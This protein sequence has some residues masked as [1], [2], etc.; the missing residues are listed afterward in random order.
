MNDASKKR[1]SLTTEGGRVT[2]NA[3]DYL[4][5]R[6]AAYNGICQSWG[7]LWNKER[8]PNSRNIGPVANVVGL[9]LDFH[10]QGFVIES[11]EATRAAVRNCIEAGLTESE[12]RSLDHLNDVVDS[13]APSGLIPYEYQRDGIVWLHSRR[14]A[15]LGD[16]MGLGKTWQ[17]LLALPRG[18]AALI[19]SPSSIKG[20]TALDAV[21]LRPDLKVTMFAASFTQ[22]EAAYFADRGIAITS[23]KRLCREGEIYITNYESTPQVALVTQSHKG[24]T[25]NQ[26]FASAQ[27]MAEYLADL[28][29]RFGD[30]IRDG[31]QVVMEQECFDAPPRGAVLIG[32][33]IHR[34][35]N[36]KALQTMRWN[37]L[38]DLFISVDGSVWGV[39]GTPMF[40]RPFDLMGVLSGLNLFNEAFG[41]FNN[42]VDLMGGSRGRYGYEWS[43]YIDPKAA[44]CMKRVM[45]RREGKDVLDMLP[46]IRY[47]DIE[48][49]CGAELQKALDDIAADIAKNGN[50]LKIVEKELEEVKAIMKP[51]MAA[52][53]QFDDENF[54]KQAM[55][56]IV[57]IQGR[58][59]GIVREALNSVVNSMDFETLTLVR[60]M[61]AKATGEA[62]MDLIEDYEEQGEA[63]VVF[64]CFR[65][66]I[67]A[68]GKRKGWVT[69]T[70]SK[71][72]IERAEAVERH[73][74]GQTAGIALTV[75]AGREGLTLT[76]SNNLIQIDLSWNPSDNS[77]A[78]FRVN[79]IGQ[80]RPVLVTRLVVNHPLVQRIH[81][82]LS[83]KERMHE[84][85]I[86]AASTRTGLAD[87][88]S[89]EAQEALAA[90]DAST[91]AAKALRAAREAEEAAKAAQRE[92]WAQ[93]KAERAARAEKRK[94][95][96]AR[97]HRLRFGENPDGTAA[98]ERH[99]PRN[100]TEAWVVRSVLALTADDPDRASIDNGV[101]FNKS[102]S[103]YGHEMA[104]IIRRGLGLTDEQYQHAA[105]MLAKYHGQIGRDP[106]KEEV[107]RE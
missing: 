99:E 16:E 100:E 28:A 54:K 41:S 59:D 76:R 37:A 84:G 13:I 85:A 19:A 88:R 61:L 30:L 58:V 97:R 83:W 53:S 91:D 38:R 93:E 86:S 31:K 49:E 102:D 56:R 87:R 89:Q 20:S 10:K 17:F 1:V 60:R 47:R 18:G 46:D 75:G 69:I 105:K 40:N 51:L 5:D 106:A 50:P 90:L 98:G 24:R 43:G 42:F 15:L 8:Y 14:F 80:T 78:V 104:V 22:R 73:Q 64:S 25:F 79:R 81:E 65:E 33:E 103:Y 66:P 35:K 70:G 12:Q 101:G 62:A 96:V 77:Q 67:E 74:G 52:L 29:E 82:L 11:D 45:L 39:S 3:L 107:G 26:R 57:S 23:E 34:V 27:D 2:V 4:G 71:S 92:R 94:V 21:R 72:A 36:R 63:P 7:M 55:E 95:E 48:V 32:D 68:L 44:D 9:V 6:F